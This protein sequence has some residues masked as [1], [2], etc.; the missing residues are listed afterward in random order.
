MII[1]TVKWQLFKTN[2]ILNVISKKMETMKALESI[3]KAINAKSMPVSQTNVRNSNLYCKAIWAIGEWALTHDYWELIGKLKSV[4]GEKCIVYN[5]TPSESDGFLHWTLFQTNTFPVIPEPTVHP[6]INKE[7]DI[8]RRLV[9]SYPYLQVNF[10]GISK[11]RHGL[12]LC[13][14]PSYDVNSLREDIRR[15]FL[16]NGYIII[17]PHPQDTAHAT[18][19]RLTSDLTA[20]EMK[21]IDTLVESYCERELAQFVPVQWEYGFGTWRQLDMERNVIASW[22]AH[23]RWI[24]HRGLLAGPN[25]ELENKESELWDR[26]HKGWDIEC[27]VWYDNETWRLGHDG[28]ND[29]IQNV[30]ALL[31]HPRA[32]IHCKNLAALQKCLEIGGVNCFFHDVDTAVLT[33]KQFIWAYPGYIVEGKMGVCVMPE[34]HGFSMTELSK[35]GSVCSDYLP[36]TFGC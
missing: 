24:L 31:T 2:F 25:K 15:E 8:L 23:P 28:P 22:K 6:S 29:N 33:S 36:T 34:R 35:T 16:K 5:P 4:L 9:Y 32:W 10:K 30:N 7:A 27:D 21:W 17:E 11:S 13:G 18:L 3:Y 19:M 14:Y 12:F 1:G 20:D 26:M